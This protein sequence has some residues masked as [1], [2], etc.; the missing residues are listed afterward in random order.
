MDSLTRENKMITGGIWQQILLFFFPLMLGSVFQLLYN[1]VD[2]M[3]VGQ[4]V[5]T[6]GIS[7]VGGASAM[8]VNLYVSLFV[9]ISTGSTVVV[10]N[11]YGAKDR[12]G[13]ENAVHTS[14]AMAIVF[15][16]ALMV[17]GI[18]TADPLLKLM[19]TPVN[20]IDASLAYLFIY[21]AGMIPNLCYNVGAGILRGIGDSKR[22]TYYLIVSTGVNI[23]LDLLFVAVLSMG[24]A[25][26][27]LATII[28]QA[29][30]AVLCIR[31]LLRVDDIYRLRIRKIRFVKG[32]SSRILKIG[33]PAGIISMMYSVSNLL[34]QACIN[35][36]GT[37]TVA[38][39]A[40]L[41]KIDSLYWMV[42]QAL[43]MAITTFVG[44][45]YGAGRMDRIRKCVPQGMLLTIILFGVYLATVFPMMRIIFGLFTRDQVVIGIGWMMTVNI[46][47]YYCTFIPEQVLESVLQGMGN[48]IVPT[49]MTVFGVC[50]LRIIWC[51]MVVPRFHMVRT[52]VWSYPVT[53]AITSVLFI[54]YFTVYM[55][56]R[57]PASI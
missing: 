13:V 11:F 14:A 6:D 12:E 55:R 40:V 47:P 9:G 35:A 28:A 4:F 17:F 50:V 41:G 26:A 37:K 8:I 29:V 46:V 7:A 15:G 33:I 21:C 36:F 1:T 56:R 57:N 22:P 39:W 10:S 23:V 16:A 38:A 25:G 45:N 30:S 44:Q 27:A 54:I 24:V 5:G 43:Q 3:V 2:T 19:N 32:Y 42:T 34:I 52:V 48:T 53:W 31:R 20:T 18:A 49:C 51:L